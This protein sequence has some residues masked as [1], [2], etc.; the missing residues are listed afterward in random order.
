MCRGKPLLS[1]LDGFL[2]A[3]SGTLHAYETIVF[4]DFV[5]ALMPF[6]R[7]RRAYA[8]AHS[9]AVAAFG[10]DGHRAHGFSGGEAQNE[11]IGA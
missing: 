4:Q 1:V 10:I 11:A 2:L 3:R 6:D 9:A 7:L 8:P 5:V